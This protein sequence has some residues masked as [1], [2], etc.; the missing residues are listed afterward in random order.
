[1]KK[2]IPEWVSYVPVKWEPMTPRV[3]ISKLTP[4]EKQTLWRGMKQIKPALAKMLSEDETLKHILNTFNGTIQ[5]EKT[6][7][8]E[9]MDA[10]NQHPNG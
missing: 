2:E 3:D 10:A 7:F 1:M 9:C 4:I 6:D 8:D 5:M